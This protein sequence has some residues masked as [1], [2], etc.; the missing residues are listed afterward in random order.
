MVAA[1]VVALL[2]LL[3]SAL[4]TMACHQWTYICSLGLQLVE[5]EPVLKEVDEGVLRDVLR[6]GEGFRVADPAAR[7]LQRGVSV[8]WRGQ[9]QRQRAGQA[10][11]NMHAPASCRYLHTR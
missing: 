10:Q 7:E 11:K 6:K 3:V 8:A 4:S 1:E 9:R 2:D 5:P